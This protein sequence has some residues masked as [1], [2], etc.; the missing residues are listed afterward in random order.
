MLQFQKRFEFW[1][2]EKTR[3]KQN[4]CFETER[5]KIVLVNSSFFFLSDLS[6][7]YHILS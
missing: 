3:T 7:F 2:I 6:F 5:W 4:R 1:Q